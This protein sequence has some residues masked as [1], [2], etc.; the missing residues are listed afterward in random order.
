MSYNPT[1]WVCQTK[2]VYCDGFFYAHSRKIPCPLKD[3]CH[4]SDRQL[5]YFY[6]Q[7]SKRERTIKNPPDFEWQRQHRYNLCRIRR[8]FSTEEERRAES[9][10]TKE[11]HHLWY[12][13]HKPKR[14]APAPK[15][16]EAVPLP[17]C[18]WACQ[19]EDG[20]CPYDDDC[21]YPDW[22]EDYLAKRKAERQKARMDRSHAKERDRM[23]TDPEFKA[24]RNA[25]KQAWKKA[26]HA[27]ES[28]AE[29]EARLSK[30]REYLARRRANET[31]E[32]REH[33]LERKR[34]DYAKNREAINARRRTAYSEK[35]EAGA[36]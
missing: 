17:P 24:A 2:A 21:R 33:R 15:P 8:A 23:Q 13:A 29:R 16:S 18:G 26:K 11:Y 35:K 14:S 32:E 3:K 6:T 31:P 28:P 34:M 27:R 10:K 30:Q 25:Y 4:G 36:T 19:E 12:L 9:M 20:V 5:E 1:R 22:E 7:H